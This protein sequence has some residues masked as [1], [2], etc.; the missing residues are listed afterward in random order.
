MKE[1]WERALAK[2]AR[3]PRK[4]EYERNY[5]RRMRFELKIKRMRETFS[6]VE[7]LCAAL[8]KS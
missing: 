7:A 2:R 8:T 3:Q 6:R 4:R 5:R 1:L